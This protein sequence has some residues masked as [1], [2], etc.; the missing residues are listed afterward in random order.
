M[1]GL[2]SY[3]VTN[4]INNFRKVWRLFSYSLVHSGFVHLLSNL[5]MLV[6]YGSILEGRLEGRRHV[7][8]A[9]FLVGSVVGALG[10]SYQS[11]YKGVVGASSGCYSMFGFLSGLHLTKVAAAEEEGECGGG[12]RGE[13]HYDFFISI[14]LFSHIF[15]DLILFTIY[16]D[17]DVAYFSHF[18]GWTSGL[19]LAMTLLAS[20]KTIS[21]LALAIFVAQ[22]YILSYSYSYFPPFS[23]ELDDCCAQAFWMIEGSPSSLTDVSDSYVCI[24]DTLY[25]RA[26]SHAASYLSSPRSTYNSFAAQPKKA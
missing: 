17:D 2:L 16:Y 11:P 13:S 22:A 20:S 5:T 4:F 24:D 23:V 12:L 25:D 7:V 3:M 10:Q 26:S 1:N 14:V 9:V 15:C 18:F 8:A 19:L 21:R 6:S